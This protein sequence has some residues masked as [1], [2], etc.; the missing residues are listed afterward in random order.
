MLISTRP[1]SVHI[2]GGR[3]L[4]WGTVRAIAAALGVEVS[5]LARL[6]EEIDGTQHA[7]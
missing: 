3:N 7:Q 1:G 5:E 6:A 2:V 4:A